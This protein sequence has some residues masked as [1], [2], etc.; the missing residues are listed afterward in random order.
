[1]K[2]V[3]FF[4]SFLILLLCF[5][6]ITLVKN[7]SRPLCILYTGEEM[8]S[9]EP[10][11][12][13]DGMLGGLPRRH[14]VIE[15][16]KQ[17]QDG[18]LL[19]ATGNVVSQ[20]GRQDEIKYQIAISAMKQMGYQAVNI[21][22]KDLTLGVDYLKYV[23][24]SF[25]APLVCAN[26]MK[27]CPERSRRDGMPL[28]SQYQIVNIGSLSVGIIG[29]ISK[30]YQY[31]IDTQEPKLTL[32]SPH[33]AIRSVMKMIKEKVELVVLIGS[34]EIEEAKGVLQKFPSI[35]VALLSSSK[36]KPSCEIENDTN[37]IIAT[38]SKKSE[39]VNKIE[40][41][42]NQNE[43]EIK[44]FS[45]EF[46]PLSEDIPDSTLM[47]QLMDLYQQMIES[48]E[49]VRKVKKKSLEGRKFVGSKAC[50]SCHESAYSIWERT[51][52]S[53]AYDTL[54]KKGKP[55]DPECLACHTVGFFYESGFVKDTETPDLVGV[56]CESCH[57]AGS[58]HIEE[59]EPM[60]EAGESSCKRCH[61]KEKSPNFKF[62]KYYPKILHWK[63]KD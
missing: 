23:Q 43:R 21:G 37:C 36:D 51:S 53:K 33:D 1:M 55:K 5:C 62:D 25:Q 11:G 57:G 39:Y 8:G 4:A 10:C 35:K 13:T 27:A 38:S 18:V 22:E 61:T 63:D 12:C 56:G 40:L 14:T 52:H 59:H 19:L 7:L 32:L 15:S 9:L 42:F 49:L 6:T 58:E 50:Q 48:E 31:L 44:D 28:F 17:S 47:T 20:A 54:I 24:E 26:L 30:K 60:D 45:Y 41:Y 34:M 29:V 16:I 2:K 46:I 3:I